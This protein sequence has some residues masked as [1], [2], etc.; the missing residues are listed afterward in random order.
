M[1]GQAIQKTI[2]FIRQMAGIVLT[3]E[4]AYFVE[5]RLSPVMR[6]EKIASLDELLLRAERGD[7]RIHQRIVD[8]LTTNETFFFRDRQPF[9]HFRDV[10]IP[11]LHARRSA[12]K[13][14]RVWCAACSSGQEP[15]SLVML[16]NEMKAKIGSRQVEI[17]ATDISETILAKAK[18]GLF[19]QFEV[20]RGL[21]TKLLLQYFVKQGDNWKL[22]DDIIRR[23]TFQKFNLMEEPR[24]LGMF[25]VVFCRNV[26][27]YFDRATR[28]KVFDRIASRI[29]PD[30]FLMLG[31]AESTFGV[32]ERFVSHPK[33]RMLLVPAPAAA[34]RPV[35]AAIA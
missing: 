13:P 7:R 5:A 31:G 25:D 30:G 29:A 3:P 6:E 12:E 10:I 22:S 21:P 2:D 16:L 15:Y 11:E 8:A 19:N 32:T 33:E 35:R 17:V 18:A 26:L 1:S 4:K 9:D 14:I 27:I 20:Q 24:S 23:V 28:A 34:Q